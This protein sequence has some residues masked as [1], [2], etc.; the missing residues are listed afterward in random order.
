MN[1][2]LNKIL[3]IAEKTPYYRELYKDKKIER[4]EDLPYANPTDLTENPQDFIPNSTKIASVITSTGTTNRPKL[5]HLTKKD[6]KEA[7][8]HISEMMRNILSKND[9]VISMYPHGPHVTGPIVF[10]ILQELELEHLAVSMFLPQ[11]AIYP[12]QKLGFNTLI[13]AYPILIR[14]IEECKNKN[15]SPRDLGIKKIIVGGAYIPL[16]FRKYIE[17]TFQANLFDAY[18][19]AEAVIIGIECKNK[20]GYH[21]ISPEYLFTEISLIDKEKGEL[22]ITLLKREGTQ[23]IRYRTGDIVSIV[24]KPCNCG[25][26]TPRIKWHGRLDNMLI[27]GH[28]N[29]YWTNEFDEAILSLPIDNFFIEIKKDKNGLDII[30]FL[31]KSDKEIEKDDII[32]VIKKIDGELYQQ[33]KDNMIKLEVT[34]IEGVDTSSKT[35]KTRKRIIDRRQYE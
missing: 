19:L 25:L 16:K 6:I 20:E 29:L 26:K 18:G 30:N 23:I 22:I 28:L 17:K 15:I 2:N 34:K 9:K 1:P 24:N 35:I 3:K 32:S 5:I 31:I 7:T 27:V 8:K 11:L 14:L 10:P 33:L 12:L 21:L 13:T 4:F